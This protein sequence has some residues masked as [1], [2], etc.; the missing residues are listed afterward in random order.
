MKIKRMRTEV[1]KR[2]GGGWRTGKERGIKSKRKVRTVKSLKV[3]SRNV[4]S[5]E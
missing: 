4:K 1:D 2:G 5:K 3:E